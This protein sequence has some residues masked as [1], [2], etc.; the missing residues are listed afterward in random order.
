VLV[1]HRVNT[2][3]VTRT[4]PGGTTYEPAGLVLDPFYGSYDTV[5]RAVSAPDSLEKVKVVRNRTDVWE[6]R[7]RGRLVY[8]GYTESTNPTAAAAQSD[9]VSRL[10][11]PRLRKRHIF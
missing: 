6:L 9:E 8:Q 7:G 5:Y 11:V 1:T 2:A 3:Q 10:L 4:I